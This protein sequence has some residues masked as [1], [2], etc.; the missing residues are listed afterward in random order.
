VPY[1]PCPAR[2][3]SP[4]GL[5]TCKPRVPGVMVR[6]Q[7]DYELVRC[8]GQGSYGVVDLWRQLRFNCD[9]VVAKR[10]TLEDLTSEQ[11][12]A[13]RRESKI[14]RSLRHP[15]IV[16]YLSSWVDRGSGELVIIQEYLSGGDLSK[17]IKA[18]KSRHHRF[19]EERVLRWFAQ[20]WHALEY[21]HT[22]WNLMHR[23]LKPNNVFLSGDFDNAYLGDF[24]VSKLLSSSTGLTDTYI[25]THLY[26][27]PEVLQKSS[28]GLKSDVWGLGTILYEVCTLTRPFE[29]PEGTAF[30]TLESIV[31]S[32]GPRHFPSE[33]RY[34]PV[35]EKVCYRM[36]DKDPSLRP[37]LG[38]VL[39]E[40]TA[41][42]AAVIQL[43]FRIS[44]EVSLVPE[45]EGN[46]CDVQDTFTFDKGAE[47]STQDSKS[48]EEPLSPSASSHVFS[49]KSSGDLN[50][51]LSY[52]EEL[53]GISPEVKELFG[54]DASTPTTATP[55]WPDPLQDRDSEVTLRPQPDPEAPPDPTVD[56]SELL[57]QLPMDEPGFREDLAEVS[58]CDL[59]PEPNPAPGRHGSTT[60]P[61]SAKV[62]ARDTLTPPTLRRQEGELRTGQQVSRCSSA[63]LDGANC[64]ASRPPS[65]LGRRPRVAAEVPIW[66]PNPEFELCAGATVSATASAFSR[67]QVRINRTRPLVESVALHHTGGVVVNRRRGH[68]NE[69]GLLVATPAA[70]PP[71][72][73]R[74]SSVPGRPPSAPLGEPPRLFGD[75]GSSATAPTSSAASRSV[76]ARSP[77]QPAASMLARRPQALPT[78]ASSPPS[79]TQHLSGCIGR[80]RSDCALHR[81][82]PSRGRDGATTPRRRGTGL[83]MR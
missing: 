35:F 78:S 74:A 25:G 29:T 8:L 57:D 39:L 4:C 69:P 62:D 47:S 28:Y 11:E 12:V 80:A 14:L 71:K 70:T 16:K 48:E 42:R 68:S 19:E 66:S 46:F 9:L 81:G 49:R 41:F 75:A 58:V 64:R 30:S 56:W 32:D 45:S 73:G 50:E 5:P 63:A 52:L 82:V 34:P 15:Y 26:M 33:A 37:S 55:Q 36:L 43:E 31:S 72:L 10:I 18:A 38:Q 40:H 2:R 54:Y 1:Q 6:P 13:A 23:D 17:A 51:P 24:G 67:T 44:W 53:A 22:Q 60:P 59:A 21:C 27:S 76:L 3:P 61:A 20:L 65:T 7:D 83:S 79:Q 77:W